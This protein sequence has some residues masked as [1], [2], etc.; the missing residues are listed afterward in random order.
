[1]DNQQLYRSEAHMTRT[2][3]HAQK[4]WS[5][6]CHRANLLNSCSDSSG[7]PNSLARAVSPEVG[8]GIRGPICA[9]LQTRVAGVQLRIEGSNGGL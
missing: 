9:H 5:Q 8:D 7:M 1:M 2:C 3:P 4:S 6:E